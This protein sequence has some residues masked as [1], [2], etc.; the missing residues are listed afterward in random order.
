MAAKKKKRGRG[1]PA[2]GDG[3]VH[4]CSFRVS[5]AVRLRV[6]ELAGTF[7]TPAHV[8]SWHE[9]A[10]AVVEGQVGR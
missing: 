1:R 2:S 8:P 6:E 4:L 10:R 5:D 7:A 9:A 3:R